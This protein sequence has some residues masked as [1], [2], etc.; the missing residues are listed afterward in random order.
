MKKN[1]LRKLLNEG[2]PTLGTHV[3][4]PWPGMIEII[5]QSKAFDYIEY[6]GEYSPFDLAL[7]D[8]FGRA[9]ELFPEMSSMMKVEEQTRGFIATRAIDAGIQNVLFTD[10][11]SADEVRD[12]VRLVRPETPEAGGT[13][14][15]GMRR[16]IGY[17][18]GSAE[19]WV[20]SMNDVVIAIMIEKK[21]AMENLEEILE[22]EGVDMVQFGPADYSIS[23]GKPGQ[24][25]R[26]EVQKAQEKMIELALKKG[27]HPRVEIAGFEEAKPFVEMGVRHFCIGWDLTV[28]FSWCLKQG[29]G[30]KSLLGKVG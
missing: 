8:N 22:V 25:R 4:T 5:G 23:I 7:L 20:R 26:L 17:V 19:E 10:C 18:Y 28:I 14:G 6:V 2:K 24:G 3:I 13:H 21:G 29:K 30:M 1:I 12:C 11:R 27:L 9:I 15:F 16:G